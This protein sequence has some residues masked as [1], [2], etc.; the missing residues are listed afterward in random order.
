M[1]NGIKAITL[2]NSV[3]RTWVQVASERSDVGE[4]NVYSSRANAP[5]YNRCNRLESCCKHRVLLRGEFWHDICRPSM[6]TTVVVMN[7]RS[8]RA[9][10]GT[11][12]SL[13]SS[14]V[15][16]S[17]RIIAPVSERV[18]RLR[19][20]K[21]REHPCPLCNMPTLDVGVAGNGMRRQLKSS[22]V[23]DVVLL[24]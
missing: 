10:T 22:L 9:S 5:L 8:H 20:E 11:K 19:E 7:R 16:S 1:K 12:F 3:K 21:A 14:G 24:L 13:P 17:A 4:G 23:K 18:L 6:A 2:A 15:N